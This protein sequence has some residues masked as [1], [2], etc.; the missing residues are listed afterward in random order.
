LLGRASFFLQGGGEF[1]LL[2]GIKWS[3]F[4]QDDWRVSPRL[5]LNLG[6]RWESYFPFTEERAAS[7]AF[8]PEH[9]PIA[10]RMHRR[11]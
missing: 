3:A 11:V 9:N 2:N 7:F 8:T 4:A 6:L 5:T 10:T 1:L